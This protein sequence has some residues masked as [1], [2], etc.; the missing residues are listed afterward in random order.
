MVNFS[1][2]QGVWANAKTMDFSKITPDPG[3]Y[4]CSIYDVSA[5]A[6]ETKRGTLARVKWI[7]TIIEGDSQGAQ[8]E[9]A[10]WLTD[11]K[12]CGRLK[13]S[14]KLLG[15]QIPDNPN[16]LDIALSPAVGMDVQIEVKRK[17][18]FSNIYIRR[19]LSVQEN[20]SDPDDLS[21]FDTPA[22]KIEAFP[23]DQFLY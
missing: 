7:F 21:V 10:D 14:M 23:D 17:G 11:E 1:M 20:Q 22:Q 8:F 16:D 13:G 15:L 3:V 2:I 4:S 18:E 6:C 12:S 5:M 19:V 9:R